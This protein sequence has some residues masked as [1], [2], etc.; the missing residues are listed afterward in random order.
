MRLIQSIYSLFIKRL[1]D[2]VF[3]IFL[4]IILSPL[5]LLLAIAIKV[6]SRGPVFFIQ[7]RL[8]KSGKIF[9]IL[10]FRTMI[11]GAESKGD[12][13]FVYAFSDSRITKVGKV[14][15]KT[16]LDELPQLVNIIKGDMSFIGPRPPVTYHPFTFDEYNDYD[17]TRFSIKPGVTGLAQ[18]KLRN[19]SSWNERIKLDIEY[20]KKISFIKDI[21][22]LIYTIVSIF[23]TEK[24]IISKENTKNVKENSNEIQ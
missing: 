2:F 20:V 1:L 23:K 10:K 22:I 15:R 7:E 3:S 21:S 14:L 16:S 17:M 12:G 5:F 13:L 18:V 4:L 6:D 24:N 11:V 9:K 19:S 8:G